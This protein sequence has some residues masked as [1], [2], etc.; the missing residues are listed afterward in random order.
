MIILFS[1]IALLVLAVFLFMKSPMFGRLPSGERAALIKASPNFRDGKFQNRHDTPDLTEGVSYY[2]VMKDFFFNK[3]PRNTPD[4]TIPSRKTDLRTLKPSENVLI[5]FGHSSYYMQLDGK[6]F[7]IDPV[8]SGAASP[9]SFTTRSF[10]GT[11]IYTVEEIPDIDYL[12]ISHDHWD[13]LDHETI[14]KLH[15][16][17]KKVVTGLGTGEHLEYWGYDK[18]MIIEKDWNE[19]ITID[20]EFSITIAPARHFSG[21]GFTRNQALWVSFVI[22]GPVHNVYVGGDSGY[23][24]HFKALGEKYGPFDLVLLECGQYNQYWKYIHMMPEQTA[25]AAIDLRAK[26]LM[27]VHWSKFSLAL[28]DWDEPILK[29]A[30]AARKL[31]LEV[32]HPLIGEKVYLDSV[33]KF[34]NWWEGVRE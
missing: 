24:D 26:R 13:H 32:V 31:N 34:S 21:R 5:W 29:V 11:D 4:D 30:D 10:L 15:S 6:K 28:H 8:L 23:D 22:R 1:I 9:V 7:L 14:L 2:T 18:S 3:S 20:N 16:K 12:L 27:P 17:V 19:T 25:Q 33:S